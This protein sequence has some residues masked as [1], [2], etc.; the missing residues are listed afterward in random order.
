VLY[1]ALY[2]L[3]IVD[4]SVA[5]SCELGGFDLQRY[6]WQELMSIHLAQNYKAPSGTVAATQY[7]AKDT[8][9]W[10]GFKPVKFRFGENA[11]KER[12]KCRLAQA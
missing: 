11:R 12:G 6:A 10:N 1:I 9:V 2:G 7:S 5:P 8:N 4:I 3:W